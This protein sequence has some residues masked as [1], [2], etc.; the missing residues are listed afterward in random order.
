MSGETGRCNEDTAP[1]L[2][3]SW[4]DLNRLT[5]CR[6][7]LCSHWCQPLASGVHPSQTRIASLDVAQRVLRDL[8]AHDVANLRHAPGPPVH[9]AIG[10][11]QGRTQRCLDGPPRGPGRRREPL[12]AALAVVGAA[13]MV[14][15]P[16]QGIR[17][18]AHEIVRA[19][20]CTVLLA[21]LRWRLNCAP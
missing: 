6:V 14:M 7:P 1:N 17:R 15:N 16:A 12:G 20:C 13:P 19:P 21:D 9:A 2:R 3:A 10:R 8:A 4:A 11:A 5:F 18:H